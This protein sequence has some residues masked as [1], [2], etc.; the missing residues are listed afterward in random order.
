M[1]VLGGKSGRVACWLVLERRPVRPLH[2]VYF[3]FAGTNSSGLGRAGQEKVQDFF[4]NVN[5]KRGKSVPF[6]LVR[7]GFRFNH[8]GAQV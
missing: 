8:G 7:R 6:G 5:P 3:H 2:V 4:A 1:G